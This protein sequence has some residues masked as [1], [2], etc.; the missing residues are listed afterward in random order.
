MLSGVINRP[1]LSDHRDAN[2]TRI[3]K[4]LFDALD[5][6]VGNGTCLLVVDLVRAN[7]DAHL[8]ACLHGVDLLDAFKSECNLLQVFKSAKM[9]LALIATRARSCGADRV[10]HLHDWSLT[11][12]AL[13]LLMVRSDRI[14]DPL[15][16][17]VTARQIGADGC[18]CSLNL[19]VESLANVMEEPANLCGANIHTKFASNGACDLRSF[20]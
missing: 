15:W 18:V 8:S 4:L 2:L 6:L 13:H 1:C 11:R 5:H 3:G 16:H 10:C 12:G 19:M 14:N 20:N 17:A 9:S 7:Q